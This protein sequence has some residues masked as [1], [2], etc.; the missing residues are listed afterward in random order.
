MDTTVFEPESSE[1]WEEIQLFNNTTTLKIHY[2]VS[3]IKS[4]VIISFKETFIPYSKG[5]YNN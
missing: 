1:K 4:G 2:Q 5:K 3:F